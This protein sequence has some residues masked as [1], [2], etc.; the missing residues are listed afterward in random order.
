MLVQK[1]QIKKL[2]NV[3]EGFNP[4]GAP[5]FEDDDSNEVTG[6]ISGYDKE[7]GS[8]TFTLFKF[9]EM[10]DDMLI[11][12]EIKILSEKLEDKELRK[13]LLNA[14]KTGDNWVAEFI[15]SLSKNK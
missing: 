12:N 9:S 5:I 3:P 4:I 11:K 7:T 1:Y 8:A 14:A 13:D 10:S 6:F 2:P 15:Q